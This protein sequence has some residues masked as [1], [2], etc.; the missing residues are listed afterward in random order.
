MIVFVDNLTE[1]MVLQEDLLTRQGRLI[2]GKGVSLQAQHLKV[3]KSWGVS[4]ADIVDNSFQHKE[5]AGGTLQQEHLETARSFITQHLGCF[6]LRHPM[7]SELVR[8]ASQRY[9]ERLASGTAFPSLAADNKPLLPAVV[10][11][12]HPTMLVRGLSDLVSLPSVYFHIVEVIH[13]PQASSAMVANI[14]SKDSNLSLKLLRLVNSAFYGFP[15][16][17]DSITRAITLLGT[18][19]LITLALGISVVQTFKHVPV[20]LID[21]EAFWKHAIRCGLFAQVLCSYKVGVSE[22]TMFVGG[23]LHDIGRLVM[24]RK[25]PEQYSRVMNYAR[26]QRLPLEQAEQQLL[27][28]THSDVGMRLGDDWNIAPNLIQMIGDHHQPARERYHTE[29]SLLH[30]SNLLAHVFGDDAPGAEAW[31]AFD[32]KAWDSQ[33]IS[34]GV[35]AAAVI[36]VDRMFRDVVNIFL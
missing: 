30:I 23:L 1:G 14:V 5:P 24:L 34:P 32:S 19:E 4:E 26:Q 10:E 31:P 17:I 35:L 8:L 12:Q 11:R 15:G 21:M 27:E 13:S 2:I 29:A 18:N 25:I 7:L 9:A 28:C 36:Q 3:L 6:D 16:Q 33:G 20:D 22:E